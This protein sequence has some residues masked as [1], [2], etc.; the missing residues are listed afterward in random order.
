MYRLARS[1][2]RPFK[3]WLIRLVIRR[4]GVDLGE[5]ADPDPDH[6]PSFNAFFTRALYPG[7]RPVDAA[8]DSLVSPADGRISQ[9]GP[10][11]D[12]RLLQAKGR[13]YRLWDLLAGEEE[14]VTPFRQGSFMTI[15]LSPRDYHRVHM[16]V[17]GRLVSMHFVPGK[18]FSVSDA[19][20]QLVPN[21][22]ARNERL[23]CRFDTAAGPM[24]M[25]LVGAI[26][27]ASIETV[28]E[29]EINEPGNN[30]SSWHYPGHEPID[31]AKGEEMG[32]FN[33]GSTVI[34][35]FPQDRVE[36]NPQLQPGSEVQVGGAIGRFRPAPAETP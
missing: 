17:S 28:W 13:D 33:M 30:V 1:T 26:F 7:V 34:L 19:T 31:L 4:Y 24:I 9:L 5:A 11:R 23:I 12:N 16:P 2:W 21:L 27:V 14:L 32:R 15:Y 8:V 35:L 3:S 20:A 18:L 10:I 25:I 6:Y 29:G 22:F 36:W